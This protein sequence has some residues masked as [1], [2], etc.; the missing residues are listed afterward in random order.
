MHNNLA[1]TYSKLGREKEAISEYEKVLPQTKEVL[2]II[3]H[4]YLKDKKYETAIRYYKKVVALD[5][6][7]ASSYASLGYAFAAQKKWDKAIANYQIALK[8]D[9]EDDE[10]YAILGEAYEGKELYP[11]ALKA[12][13]SA[14]ELNPESAKAARRIPALKIKFL[15]NKSQK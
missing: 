8:Y 1:Y 10:L 12:Y 15:Q 7:K 9:K 5:P 14:Y 3:A 11:E 6:K 13:T 2:S 4:Y